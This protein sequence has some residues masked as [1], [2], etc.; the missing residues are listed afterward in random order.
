VK[1]ITSSCVIN[2]ELRE[3]PGTAAPRLSL[4]PAAR[5]QLPHSS[6]PTPNRLMSNSLI[7]ALRNTQST[8]GTPCC[9]YIPAAAHETSI[10]I[11]QPCVQRYAHLARTLTYWQ[12]CEYSLVET[13]FTFHSRATAQF[14]SCEYST[15]YNLQH[16]FFSHVTASPTA[17]QDIMARSDRRAELFAAALI[18]YT[19]AAVAL[20]LRNVARRKTRVIMFWEDYLAIVAFVSLCTLQCNQI[21]TL[22]K[23]IGTGFTFISLFS[24]VA[25]LSGSIVAN[26]EQRHDGDLVFLWKTFSVP[27]KRSNTTTFEIF[28][29]TCVMVFRLAT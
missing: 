3:W 11:T 15:S 9:M 16:I 18:P 14:T 22:V 27:R 21:L 29:Q 20:I 24:K 8:W 17:V 1:T 2:F 7:G 12:S 19:A 6:T 25:S 23:V 13:A 10:P 4:P 28:G 5:H 26:S